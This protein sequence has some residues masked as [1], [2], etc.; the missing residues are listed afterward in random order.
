MSCRRPPDPHCCSSDTPIVSVRPVQGCAGSRLSR[1]QR[2]ALRF[3]WPTRRCQLIIRRGY[4]DV[5][6]RGAA[7]SSAEKMTQTSTIK[8]LGLNVVPHSCGPSAGWCER[9]CRFRVVRVRVWRVVTK[10]SRGCC[11][12]GLFTHARV[13]GMAAISYYCCGRRPHADV[14]EIP[15]QNPHTHLLSQVYHT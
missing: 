5:L 10:C 15:G 8:L 3:C 1:A 4:R 9:D 11:I 13:N 7:G 6:M 2:T 14:Y 12:V